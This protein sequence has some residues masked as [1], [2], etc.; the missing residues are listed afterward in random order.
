MNFNKL[1]YTLFFIVIIS[2]SC[3]KY[4]DIPAPTNQ[5]VKELVFSDDKTA[6]ATVAGLYGSFN[7]FNS[8]FG[9]T[10]TN[11][12]PAFSADEFRY[13]LNSATYDEFSQNSI[14]SS[15]TSIKSAW[16]NAYSRIYHANAILE[17]LESAPTVSATVKQQLTGEAKFLRAYCY[18]YLVNFFGDV[19]LVLNTDFK[20]STLLPKTPLADVYAN[21][22]KDLTE[23]QASLGDS[24]PTTERIRANKSV[25]TALLARVYLYRG[26]WPK[27]EAEATKI[28]SN[29]SYK[30]VTDLNAIFLKN[31]TETILQWQTTNTSTT[32]VN[33][34]EGFSI[35]PSS[36][37]SNTGYYA[38]DS[39]LAA[40]ET[41]DQRKS[42][43]IKPITISGNTFYYPY[44]YKVRTGSPVTEYSMVFRMAEQYL[45]R[46][47][48]RAQQNNLTGAKSDI[49]EI[50]KRAGLAVLPGTLTK[51]QTLLA[52]EQERR[53]ELF[54]EGGHRWFDLKR[55][56]RAL[57]VL[58]PIKP[59]IT[60]RDLL[61]PLPLDAILTNPNLVQ[62]PGYN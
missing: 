40:F 31:S 47:E 52:I 60:G 36:P 18:F 6:S 62:N 25:A 41:G 27:A 4:V 29:T 8:S 33:T 44:K 26:E 53:I 35:V 2:A 14:T 5:L 30:L 3:K 38:Y 11:F 37:T 58:A 39:F 10:I 1:Y 54:A 17:G 28:I 51:D 50:R 12:L 21:I 56:G 55:T 7:S 59:N 13:T 32:G 16:D 24:Y 19:P 45:I 57:T 61:Y 43:W 22:T 34:W 9:N 15:N 20:T 23:A 49:D 46:A 48:A 42:A